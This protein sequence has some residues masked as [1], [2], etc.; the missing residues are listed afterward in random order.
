MTYSSCPS[1]T[2]T[3]RTSVDQAGELEVTL[4]RLV[5]EGAEDT[6]QTLADLDGLIAKA[7]TPRPVDG[8][9]GLVDVTVNLSTVEPLCNVDYDGSLDALCAS[10]A[11]VG[12]TVTDMD[13]TVDGQDFG[14]VWR[15]AFSDGILSVASFGSLD[16]FT[17]GHG[18]SAQQI[19][20]TGA[21]TEWGDFA[22]EV[23]GAVS[24]QYW[25]FLWLGY[26]VGQALSRGPVTPDALRARFLDTAQRQRVGKEID[27]RHP[28]AGA[29]GSLIN[30]AAEGGQL[31]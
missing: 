20:D 24:P 4:H 23:E 16:H 12:F 6:S 21:L 7:D 8:A 27:A 13:I 28:D 19:A 31:I 29:L 10:L 11:E 15:Y 1:G 17:A 18:R 25:E 3:V 9:P 14:D 26:Q 5:D 2:L 30:F 22:D